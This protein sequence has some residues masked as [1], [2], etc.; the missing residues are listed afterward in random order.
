M[1]TC[2]FYGHKDTP[3]EVKPVLYAV[4]KELITQ[5]NVEV[6]YVGNQGSFDFYTRAALRQLQKK[7]PHIWRGFIKHYPVLLQSFFL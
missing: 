5:R 3:E 2:C 4:I 6:F 7:Y 1:S